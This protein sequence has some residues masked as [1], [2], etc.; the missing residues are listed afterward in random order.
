MGGA[1]AIL[2]SPSTS[3]GEFRQCLQA[4]LPSGLFCMTFSAP[5]RTSP[6]NSPNRSVALRCEYQTSIVRMPAKF[7]MASR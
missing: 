3:I 1:L 7:S 5:L 2:Y 4:V 6:F